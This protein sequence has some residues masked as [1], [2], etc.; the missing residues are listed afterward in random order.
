MGA[1]LLA[2]KSWGNIEFDSRLLINSSIKIIN[3]LIKTCPNVIHYLLLMRFSMQNKII[4]AVTKITF[5]KDSI[6]R[7]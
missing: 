7:Q 5:I 2:I 6:N 3:F 1:L 4:L